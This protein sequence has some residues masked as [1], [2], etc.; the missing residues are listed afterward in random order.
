MISVADSRRCKFLPILEDLQIGKSLLTWAVGQLGHSRAGGN[1]E[2][3]TNFLDSRLRGNDGPYSAAKLS[4]LS[5]TYVP[6][7]MLARKLP[8]WPSHKRSHGI[9]KPNALIHPLDSRPTRMRDEP[10]DSEQ[11]LQNPHS[12]KRLKNS[13]SRAV[14]RSGNPLR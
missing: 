7:L 12:S 14:A 3:R 1:P 10:L 11:L 5:T 9:E 4:N 6:K 13:V 8:R 2:L